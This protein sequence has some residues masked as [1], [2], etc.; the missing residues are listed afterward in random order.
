MTSTSRYVVRCALTGIA[1][2]ASSLLTALPGVSL[3]DLV[4]A[5]LLGVIFGLGYAGIGAASPQ[6]EPHIGNKPDQ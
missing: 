3:D 6:V 1:S 5:G 2:A 4:Q